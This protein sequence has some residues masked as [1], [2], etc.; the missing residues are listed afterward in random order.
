VC[1]KD[2]KHLDHHK[3]FSF[4]S[5]LFPCP[6]H[7]QVGDALDYLHKRKIIYRDL[8]SD[9][10]LAW[11][12]P[13]PGNS[14]PATAILVKLADYGISKSVFPGGEAKGFG[15]TPPF[16][17]PEIIAHTGRD[18]YTEKVGVNAVFQLFNLE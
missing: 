15:G 18:T 17:A 5:K 8:K 14:N 12:F 1:V 6:S 3:H 13:D 9:N 2:I 10:V 11:H 4:H 7:V 16:I